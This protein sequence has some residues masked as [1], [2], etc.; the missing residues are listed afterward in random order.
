MNERGTVYSGVYRADIKIN[1]E[2]EILMTNK[3]K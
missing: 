2:Q 3:V 1:L